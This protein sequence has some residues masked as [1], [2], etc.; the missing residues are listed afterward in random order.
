MLQY[1]K[2]KGDPAMA[3]TTDGKKL[4]YAERK[5]RASPAKPTKMPVAELENPG[6]DLDEDEVSASEASENEEDEASENEASENEEDDE[7]EVSDD[8]EEEDASEEEESDEEN[9]NELRAFNQ[10]IW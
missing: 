2:Q 6:T 1:K 4:Q 3:K 9:R 10:P 8:E 7:D 5:D